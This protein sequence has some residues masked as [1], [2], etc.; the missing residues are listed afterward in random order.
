MLDVLGKDGFEVSAAEDEHPVE[1]FAPQ[2]ADHTLTD[3]IRPG[4]AD[5]DLMILMPS[6]AKTASKEPVN[7]VSRSRTKNLIAFA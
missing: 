7:L 2:C 6:A 5:R 1:A 4:R 3:R